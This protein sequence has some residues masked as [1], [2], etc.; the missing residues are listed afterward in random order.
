MGP[1]C[2]SPF[3]V[4]YSLR[5]ISNYEFLCLTMIFRLIW[6]IF[7]INIF[8]LLDDNTSIFNFIKKVNKVDDQSWTQNYGYT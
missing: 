8:L 7:M 2:H 5:L 6:K 1:T 3:L 4:V